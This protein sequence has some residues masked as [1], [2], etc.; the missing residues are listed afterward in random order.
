MQ[1]KVILNIVGIHPLSRAEEEEFKK[2]MYRGLCE[3]VVAAEDS[4]LR[5][6]NFSIEA[7]AAVNA[8]NRK[9]AGT[10]RSLRIWA[11]DQMAALRI[12]CVSDSLT[13]ENVKDASLEA[14]SYLVDISNQRYTSTYQLTMINQVNV[15]ITFVLF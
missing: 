9:P 4:A 14:A 7:L 2:D 3:A 6:S 10:T 5:T 11:K 1:C 8:G 15:L 12:T 13:Y